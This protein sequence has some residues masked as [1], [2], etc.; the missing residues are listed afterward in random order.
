VIV[1]GVG[2]YWHDVSRIT[3]LRAKR[4][5]SGVAG[6]CDGANSARVGL[7]LR[8]WAVGDGQGG[9]LSNRV[10]LGGG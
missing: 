7:G 6:N 3:S 4:T 5:Y 9:S 10:G 2:Q 8:A 1:V